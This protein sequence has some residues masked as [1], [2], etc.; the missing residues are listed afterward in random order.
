MGTH[1]VSSPSIKRLVH[2]NTLAHVVRVQMS[3]VW[4]QDSASAS[5]TF[6]TPTP[7]LAHSRFADVLE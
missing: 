5:A 2:V 7:F 3:T 4:G 6:P 1:S